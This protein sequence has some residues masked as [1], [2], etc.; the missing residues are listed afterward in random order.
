MADKGIFGYSFL[1][2]RGRRDSQAEGDSQSRKVR[3]CHEGVSQVI[4]VQP[5]SSE[6]SL[7]EDYESALTQWVLD[8]ELT[9]RKVKQNV[10]T[11]LLD[12]FK[13]KGKSL[14]LSDYQLHSV[15]PLFGLP[16][17]IDIDL[18]NNEISEISSTTFSHQCFLKSLDL[19][20]NYLERIYNL[21]LSNR[22][23][24]VSLDL[25][26]NY[27]D[28]I[29]GMDFSNGLS[30]SDLNISNNPIRIFRNLKFSNCSDMVSFQLFE[31]NSLV[32]IENVDFSNCTGL[33]AIT[34][35]DTSLERLG[36]FN[37]KN[38]TELE[39]IIL[40]NN[41]LQWMPEW[42]LTEC[43][44]LF[45]MDL[46]HNCLNEFLQGLRLPDRLSY[47]DLQGNDFIE[48]DDWLFESDNLF[49][50]RF[51]RQIN[52]G[53]NLFSPAYVERVIDRQNEVG[54]RKA[55]F[56][57]SIRETVDQPTSLQDL[58][59]ILEKWGMC[60]KHPIWQLI[61]TIPFN[62]K[63]ERIYLD[64]VIF[65]VRLYNETPRESDGKSFPPNVL[66]H[67]KMILS[68]LEQTYDSEVSSSS[69]NLLKQCCGIVSE[70]TETCSDKLAIGMIHLSLYVQ[71]ALARIQGD[72]E[73][74]LKMNAS[75][76]W[77]EKISNFIRELSDYKIVYSLER[78]S[79]V[80]LSEFFDV[81]I[82]YEEGCVVGVDSFSKD[83]RYYIL[84]EKLKNGEKIRLFN[85]GD[86]VEDIL[87]LLNMLKSEGL[88]DIDSVEMKYRRCA[89]LKEPSLQLAVLT[90][91]KSIS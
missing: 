18:C 60:C 28:E 65:L 59:G 3:S 66:F 29:D 27:I 89:T 30:F 15:P 52:M 48:L 35:T 87:Q 31:L 61:A 19:S 46:S 9:S 64:F 45:R 85:V 25:S 71:R 39:M 68:I 5:S 44:E 63:D 23:S 13:L 84:Q 1:S 55:R 70:Y 41:R 90:Y 51:D 4:S 91:L 49:C 74:V 67:V 83:E 86:E 72:D 11:K 43:D 42:D 33:N 58:L 34:I 47:L 38:C 36:Y 79:F 81:P 54:Y 12:L 8:D 10:K 2:F 50:R 80:R 6:D 21:D 88:A 75:L 76:Q 62:H 78:E 37:F 22:S 53:Q 20:R 16:Q 69:D 17:L 14:C 24:L 77:L 82:V 32:V 57:M 56:L 73:I 26:H 7:F 40:H